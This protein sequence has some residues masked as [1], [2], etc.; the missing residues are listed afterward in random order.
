MTFSLALNNSEGKN[1]LKLLA[2]IK[3]NLHVNSN[4]FWQIYLQI[5]WLLDKIKN[6]ISL[7]FISI[8]FPC[9]KSSSE[10]TCA[11]TGN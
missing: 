1:I 8:S 6:T 11:Y 7:R 10:R 3:S 5:S 2:I 4:Y 9:K